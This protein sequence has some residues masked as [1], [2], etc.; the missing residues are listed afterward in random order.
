MAKELQTGTDSGLTI[1]SV[2]LN[3]EG[4]IYNGVDFES[5]NALNWTTYDI[6]MTEATAGIYLADMPMLNAGSY[7][8][9]SYSQSGV[10]PAIA[11]EQIGYGFI[12]WD[13]SAALFWEYDLHELF[14]EID[15]IKTL[16]RKYSTVYKHIKC[17]KMVIGRSEEMIVEAFGVGDLSGRT[18]LYF[19][20]KYL[21]EKDSA[22]DAQS[23]IQIKETSGLLYINKAIAITP[24]N[25]SITVTD[26]LA[27]TLTIRLAAEETEK[28]TPN[29]QYYYDIRMDNQIMV[30]GKFLIS[31]A[32]TR[33]LT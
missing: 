15:S 7:L 14:I 19:T 16:L 22:T 5:I 9:I 12:A 30:Y 13:G 10:N 3:N 27:G 11:D 17:A 28:L 26:A 18:N 25:G 20:V 29:E 24:A 21:K 31:T 6:S 2:L 4:E 32:I 23:I 33:T 1:Y 8:Y